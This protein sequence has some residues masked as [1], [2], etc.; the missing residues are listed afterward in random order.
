MTL[1]TALYA[2]LLALLFLYL[3]A[4][5]VQERRAHGV[6]V[7][8]G[9]QK[10]VIK[11]IRTQANCA[12]YAPLGALL[13]ICAELQG[14]P[15]WLV[16]L[17]GLALVLGRGLHAYGFG[18]TP[19]VVPARVWGMYLTFGMIAFAAIANIAMALF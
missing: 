9:G 1:I 16:H 14:A 18:S 15:G 5:V 12:E 13:L 19:Q 10:S 17:M 3:S 6:S 4:R 11:A 8:D 7:G 2:G